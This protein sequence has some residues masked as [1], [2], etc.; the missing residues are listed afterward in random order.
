[1][2]CTGSK[3]QLMHR[4]VNTAKNVVLNL[5]FDA[6]CYLYLIIFSFFKGV[7]DDRIGFVGTIVQ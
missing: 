6:E 4:K 7:N 5:H 1:M 2:K 3:I